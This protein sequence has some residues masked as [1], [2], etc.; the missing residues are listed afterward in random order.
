MRQSRIARILSR[1]MIISNM[2]K[3]ALCWRTTEGLKNGGPISDIGTAVVVNPLSRVGAVLL[4]F[5]VVYWLVGFFKE[6]LKPILNEIGDLYYRRG[7]WKRDWAYHDA[8]SLGSV[9]SSIV[10]FVL[11]WIILFP[12]GIFVAGAVWVLVWSGEFLIPTTLTGTWI[13]LSWMGP[14]SILFFILFKIFVK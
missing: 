1:T 11:L 4:G 2:V 9:I 8:F 5:C 3:F 10:G 12:I 14:G 7:R 6:P 13:S